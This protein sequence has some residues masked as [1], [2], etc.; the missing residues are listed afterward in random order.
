VSVL[1]AGLGHGRMASGPFPSSSAPPVAPSDL[2]SPCCRHG[3]GREGSYGRREQKHHAQHPVKTYHFIVHALVYARDGQ[4]CTYTNAQTLFT[5][6]THER[7]GHH[8]T[9]HSCGGTITP[10]L[11]QLL[12]PSYSVLA[13]RG[14]VRPCF[15]TVRISGYQDIRISGSQDIRISGYQDIYICVLYITNSTYAR[16][17]TVVGAKCE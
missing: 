3:T 8:P 2:F 15:A 16:D 9:E 12:C 6:S 7:T 17:K 10:H 14:G 5:H 11:F 13:P 4:T 1:H